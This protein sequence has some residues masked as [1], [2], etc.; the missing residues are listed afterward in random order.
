MTFIYSKFV[1]NV[2]NAF[3]KKWTVN[4]F[5]S[6]LERPKWHHAKRNMQCGDVVIIQDSKLKRSQWKL[7]VICRSSKG[8]DGKVRRV[9]VEYVNL[10]PGGKT[11]REVVERSVQRLVIIVPIEEQSD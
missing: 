11:T 1:Q 8:I 7:G 3:W 2:V 6:L 5:P 4:Y 9:K 10:Q